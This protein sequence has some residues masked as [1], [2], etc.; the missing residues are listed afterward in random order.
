MKKI[1]IH[2]NFEIYYK[3]SDIAVFVLE[4]AVAYS[5]HV[6]P[7]C[8]PAAQEQFPISSICYTGGWGYMNFTREFKNV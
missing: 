2:E 3:G 6:R 4:I 8:L 5:D 7:L 1:T